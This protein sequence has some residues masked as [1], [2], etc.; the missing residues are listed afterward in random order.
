M[1]WISVEDRLPINSNENEDVL[2]YD[3]CIIFI[4]YYRI[5]TDCWYFMG[6]NGYTEYCDVTHW[7][8]MPDP[9]VG[10]ER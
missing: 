7:M 3:G 4:G 6:E 1:E 10:K 2:I 9:P 8:P 5:E